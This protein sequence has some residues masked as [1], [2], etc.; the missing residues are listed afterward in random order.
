LKT[1][2]LGATGEAVFGAIPMPDRPEIGNLIVGMA[3]NVEGKIID[4]VI[5]EIQDEHGSPSR[6]IK[7]ILWPI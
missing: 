1:E 5:V 6:V 4:G 3:T 2:K 7:Q